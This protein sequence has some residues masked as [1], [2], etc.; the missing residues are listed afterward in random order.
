MAAPRNNQSKHNEACREK[1][2]TTQLINRLQNSVLGDGA[3]ELTPGQL[4]AIEI[5]LRK[6]LPDLSNVT[7]QGN[8]DSP[9]ETA[10]TVTFVGVPK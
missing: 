6:S 8:P 7:V 3:K 9:L 2:Q 10:M 5:L 1:I 4:K